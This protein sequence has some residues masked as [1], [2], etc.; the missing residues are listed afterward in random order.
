[1]LQPMATLTLASSSL[2]SHSVN[3]VC[4]VKFLLPEDQAKSLMKYLEFLALIKN[5]C[6]S[7]TLS[8]VTPKGT[9]QA[10]EMRYTIAATSCLERS[11]SPLPDL[12]SVSE[13]MLPVPLL[14]ESL[15]NFV[16]NL[17]GSDLELAVAV[18][19]YVRSITQPIS[20][21]GPEETGKEPTKG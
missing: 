13:R 6:S 9:G 2:D 11:K 8:I 1:M 19:K 4:Q 15:S 12:L 7:L 20:I 18:L 16:T 14:A 10:R 5:K 17:S 21:V 3:P